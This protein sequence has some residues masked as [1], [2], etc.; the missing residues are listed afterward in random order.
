MPS[1][2]LTARE[3]RVVFR[4]GRDYTVRD[5][6]DAAYFH[7][8]LKPSWEE[9]LRGVAAEQEASESDLEADDDIVGSAVETFRYERDL[10]T[11][12]ETERWLEERGV[13]LEDFGDY[14]ARVYWRGTLDAK[15][16]AAPIEFRSA[17]P[18]LRELLTA[19]LLLS[20]EFDR[21]VQ[22]QSWLIA[23]SYAAVGDELP[24]ELIEAERERFFAREGITPDELPGLLEQLERDPSWFD[25]MT[26][27]EATHRRQCEILLSGTAPNQE[28]ANL[29]LSLTRFDLEIVEVDSRDA[30][31]EALL[32]V[33]EDGMSME[34]VAAEGRY[35]YR[36][37]TILLEDIPMDSQQ[38]FLSVSPG[39]VLDPIER[40]DG[41][42]LCRVAG[43]RNQRWTTR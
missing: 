38:N 41:F 36:S 28:L 1:S 39:A 32:C 37:A 25:E 6:I 17:S 35:P 29:R 34:E 12:E 4:C 24:H 5:V 13:T 15:G 21:M 43:N 26:S 16:T 33:R 10:I 11:A 40:G 42:Q 23:A 3:S 20:G 22:R 30:A 7:G 27:L 19:E 9:F 31:A 8:E 18:E 14:F 2:P